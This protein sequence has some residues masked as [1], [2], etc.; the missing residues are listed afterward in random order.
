MGRRWPRGGKNWREDRG[1]E[2][3]RET[4]IGREPRRERETNEKFRDVNEATT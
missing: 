3:G 4:P 2:E 1:T